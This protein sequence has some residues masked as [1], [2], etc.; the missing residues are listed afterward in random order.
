VIGAGAVVTRDC[1]PDGL[2][3]GVPA[4]RVRDLGTGE[5][6]PGWDRAS[7]GASVPVGIDLRAPLAT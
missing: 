6:V 3:V 2:Y 4:R 5:T 7:A 1:A